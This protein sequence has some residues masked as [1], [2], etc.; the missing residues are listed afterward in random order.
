MLLFL[1]ILLNRLWKE[2][3]VYKKYNPRKQNSTP[4]RRPPRL[5]RTNITN[6]YI[7]QF[8]MITDHSLLDA[9]CMEKWMNPPTISMD[10]STNQGTRYHGLL[11]NIGF[12]CLFQDW[13]TYHSCS[14]H[15]KDGAE[16]LEERPDNCLKLQFLYHL[17]G[18]W[19]LPSIPSFLIYRIIF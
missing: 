11:F 16:K 13:I 4:N 10:S 5:L 18:S 3:T 17:V 6:I 15:K 8:Q 12:C 14:L 9:A 19:V 7:F 1:F 2:A